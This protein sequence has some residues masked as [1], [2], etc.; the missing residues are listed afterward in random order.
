MRVSG[1][2]LGVSGR[3]DGVNK[4]E[5]AD[6]LCTEAAALGVA[7]CDHVG[8]AALGHVERLM[9]PLD[10]TSTANGPQALHRHVEHCPC[11]R[12]FPC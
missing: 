1:A 6:D 4:D 10:H 9:K 3:E 11:Q 12:Q 2:A 5:S 8:T 7:V